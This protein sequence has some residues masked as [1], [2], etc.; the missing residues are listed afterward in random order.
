[1]RAAPLDSETK[2]QGQDGS[3]IGPIVNNGTLILNQ[4]SDDTTLSNPISGSGA[5]V[6]DA[7]NN[8]S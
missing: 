7:Q 4:G 5:V 2:T 8:V 6:A 3:V 1:M